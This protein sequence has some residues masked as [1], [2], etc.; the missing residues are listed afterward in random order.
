[1]DIGAKKEIYSFIEELIE[2]GI[3]IVLISSEME[4]I[5]RLADRILVLRQGRI[6]RVMSRGEASEDAIVKAAA[7]AIP[8]SA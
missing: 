3:A 7:L 1:V 6:A 5:L 8:E 2:Q 4:E